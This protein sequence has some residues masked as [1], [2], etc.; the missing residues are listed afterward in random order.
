MFSATKMVH[1]EFDF[2]L[3]GRVV[4]KK[5]KKE[6]QKEMQSDK[7]DKG[8]LQSSTNH[9]ITETSRL[10]NSTCHHAFY[11]RELSREEFSNF[12]SSKNHSDHSAQLNTFFPRGAPCAVSRITVLTL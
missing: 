8:M 3:V 11:T 2:K 5:R 7:E 12:F 6:R 9:T 4:V 10:A 1:Q